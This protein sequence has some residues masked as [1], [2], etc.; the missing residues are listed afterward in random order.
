MADCIVVGGG[1]V[2]L[3]TASV[4]ADAGAEVSLF[5]RGALDGLVDPLSTGVLSPLYPWREE[6]AVIDIVNWSQGSIPSSAF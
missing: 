3:L 5:D 6:D 1:V 2:G 4:L